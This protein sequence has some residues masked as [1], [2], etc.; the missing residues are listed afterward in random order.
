M[1]HWKCLLIPAMVFS[2]LSPPVL[3]AAGEEMEEIEEMEEVTATFQDYQNAVQTERAAYLAGASITDDDVTT[4]ELEVST[5]AGGYANS[6]AEEYANDQAD[7]HV[8]DV[9]RNYANNVV[10]I[11]SERDEEIKLEADTLVQEKADEYARSVNKDMDSNEYKEAYE[12]AMARATDPSFNNLWDTTYKQLLE[13]ELGSESTEYMAWLEAYDRANQR[14]TGGGEDWV[15]ARQTAYRLAL[16]QF[17]D[18]DEYKE[19]FGEAYDEALA[20][21]MAVL[22][23][24]K[25]QLVYEMRF[26]RKW[27]W[28]RI[29]RELGLPSKYN[30][31]GQWPKG[32][33]APGEEILP[34][35][36]E[37]M[38]LEEEIAKATH[39]DTRT[40]WNKGPGTSAKS[41]G[42]SKKWI[43]LNETSFKAEAAV[44]DVGA[45][46]G[47]SSNGKGGS[48]AG[49]GKSNNSNKSQTSLSSV[50]S[51]SGKDKS[52][53]GNNG[54]RA[55]ET[56]ARNSD[57]NDRGIA[58]KEQQRQ[59]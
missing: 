51:P 25:S 58:V 21:K 24:Q 55:A 12:I 47:K 46:N 30:G 32:M 54:K 28:G 41:K 44:S 3:W 23:G 4:L 38:S 1:K 11:S 37:E 57:K 49:A 45:G 6:F 36:P 56:A 7:Q 22:S 19:L 53:N 42:N 8:K 34:P 10:E 40:G 13:D 15:D 39:R 5:Q 35:V 27:G 29:T 52:N 16:E 18:T 9:S 50:S 2:L 43:G 14:A 33:P 48:S 20:A 26:K 17:P 59:Q 31:V